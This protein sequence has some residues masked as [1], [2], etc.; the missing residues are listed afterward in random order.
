M[1]YIVA[2]K[3]IRRKYKTITITCG[4]KGCGERRDILY[5]W[6]DK[7]KDRWVCPKCGKPND[8]EIPE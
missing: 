5:K 4:G 8:F 6:N 2:P 7:G 1:E 3:L